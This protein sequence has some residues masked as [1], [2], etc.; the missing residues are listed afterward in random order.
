MQIVVNGYDDAASSRPDAAQQGVVLAEV[1]HQVD[2][3]NE[4]EACS[5]IFDDNPTAVPTAIVDQNDLAR[6]EVLNQWLQPPISRGRLVS[7]LY[8]GTTTEMDS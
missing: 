3:P 2:A 8:T 7:E 5:E 6:T 4:L 1:A